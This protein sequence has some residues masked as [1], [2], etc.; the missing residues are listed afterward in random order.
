M[1]NLFGKS[2]KGPKVIDKVWLSKQG[3]L[4]A[5]AQ[6]VKIDP[7]VLL[8]S[9]FEETFREMESQPGLAQNI[10][11]AEQVSYDKAVGRMVVFAEHYPLTSVEQDLFSKLQLKEVPVLS[12][13]E[14]PLFTAFGGER[15]IEAMKNLG[16]SEDEV[17]GHS[18]VTRS[19]R[20]AQEKIAESS[21]T[22]YPA[23]SAKE[24]FTLNLKEK[25]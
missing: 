24:W 25:K 19:I 4:N 6:M 8:V 7:S 5:C 15:I 14:E 22:D 3:K 1:F 10:I 13:L 2:S 11:K 9:W 16:L 18:M 23:T 20:N 17:I 21:G 12:S